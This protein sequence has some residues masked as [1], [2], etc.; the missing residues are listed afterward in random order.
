[1]G[2]L[3]IVAT[4][5]GNRHD[6]TLRALSVLEQAQ[7][8][9]AED[10][11]QARKLFSLYPD[12][13]FEA[14]V[15]RLDEHVVGLR[16][17]TIVDQIAQGADAALVSDAGTPQ[18]SDPGHLLI[19]ACLARGIPVTPVP[20]P[21]AL[22][23]LL[24]VA[25]FPVQPSLFVGFL[26]KK[27]GR[28]TTLRRLAAMGGKYGAASVVLYESPERVAR[29]LADLSAQFGAET[30]LVVGRELTKQHEEVWYGSVAEA[31]AHFAAPRGEFAL[32]LKLP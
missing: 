9:L 21:S 26:P 6:I 12:H 19:Q 2:T 18:V 3:S 15:L 16:L 24:S 23:A 22:A 28:E 8:I 10:T 31:Q 1:M 7:L 11:R 20:G 32:L 4:P 30:H 5:I 25:D 17:A 29:T 14:Q 13:R 27:K